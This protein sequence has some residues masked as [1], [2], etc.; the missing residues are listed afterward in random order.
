MDF[1]DLQ[2]LMQTHLSHL[3]WYPTYGRENEEDFQS[4]L[5]R[6]PSK[7]AGCKTKLINKAS[8]LTQVNLGLT[9]LPNHIMLSVILPVKLFINLRK[10]EGVFYE[11]KRQIKES[12]TIS[13]R[14]NVVHH[15][16][17]MG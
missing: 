11:V 12:G 6:F 10:L 7:L 16:I 5:D 15:S 14:M 8:R 17:V 9:F 1:P 2:N 13:S 4:L 3:S